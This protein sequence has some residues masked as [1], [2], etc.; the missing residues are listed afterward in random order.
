[1]TTRNGSA[2]PRYDV[3]AAAKKAIADGLYDGDDVVEATVS[4][5]LDRRV[6]DPTPT[7]PNQTRPQ[8]L[9]EWARSSRQGNMNRV[10]KIDG[11]LGRGFHL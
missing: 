2:P 11:L 5:L 10:A 6:L 9:A 7:L 1:M 3:V 8:L 4:A